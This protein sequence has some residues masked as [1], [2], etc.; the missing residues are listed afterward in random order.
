MSEVDE[1]DKN[2]E[3][4]KVAL[5]DNDSLYTEVTL[6][7]ETEEENFGTENISDVDSNRDSEDAEDINTVG[8]ADSLQASVTNSMVRLETKTDEILASAGPEIDLEDEK[9]EENRD[10]DEKEDE[11]GEIFPLVGELTQ[12]V[13]DKMFRDALFLPTKSDKIVLL[14]VFLSTIF[15]FVTDYYTSGPLV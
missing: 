7:S 13:T 14:F 6:S 11:S 15:D 10:Y 3:N 9:T 4:V 8:D 1:N 2:D 12:E 5:S